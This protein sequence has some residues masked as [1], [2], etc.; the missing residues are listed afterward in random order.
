MYWNKNIAL[1]I[2]N[3]SLNSN[4]FVTKTHNHKN[5]LHLSGEF[6][7]IKPLFLLFFLKQNPLEPEGFYLL[8]RKA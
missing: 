2:E 4:Y 8:D 3:S 5:Y 7:A 1:V 6:F